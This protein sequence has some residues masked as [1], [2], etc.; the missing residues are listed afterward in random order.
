MGVSAG[1]ESAWFLAADS[2]P[3]ESETGRILT[4]CG[5]TR[6]FQALGIT[7]H[8][9]EVKYLE[10]KFE[11]CFRIFYVSLIFVC[12]LYVLQRKHFFKKALTMIVNVSIFP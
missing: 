11:S 7:A 4:P 1:E 6:G 12:L 10:V 8:L 9:G 3:Q 5:I 2:H